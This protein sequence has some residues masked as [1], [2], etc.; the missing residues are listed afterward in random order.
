MTWGGA[1]VVKIET[2]YIVG[3]RCR[4]HSETILCSPVSW[5]NCLP[6]NWALVAK[7]LVPA[8]SGEEKP[9]EV[10]HGCSRHHSCWL[11][12]RHHQ[13]LHFRCDLFRLVLAVETEYLLHLTHECFGGSFL[14]S[15]PHFHASWHLRGGGSEATCLS[16]EGGSTGSQNDAPE[17][18]GI[19]KVLFQ[20]G[21]EVGFVVQRM[22]YLLIVINNC[23]A[24][25]V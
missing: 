22:N 7:R 9:G 10:I 5:K 1:D 3:V 16:H 2:K 18:L 24:V 23:V 6:R 14:S 17:E 13:D 8:G 20:M 11:C 4:S 25:A 21:W 15:L 19:V 12:S